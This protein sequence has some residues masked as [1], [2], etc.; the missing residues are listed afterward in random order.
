MSFKV[1]IGKQTITSQDQQHNEELALPSL[2]ICSLSGYKK[3][4]SK[5]QDFD[6]KNYLNN[7]LE[8]D[9]ILLSVDEMTIEGE[10]IFNKSDSWNV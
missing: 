1:F 8:L 2:T 4:I 10:A 7:T 5:Y 3:K 9:E 6:L